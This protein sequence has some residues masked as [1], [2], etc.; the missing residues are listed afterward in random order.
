MKKNSLLCL[1]CVCL[2]LFLSCNAIQSNLVGDK[3]RKVILGFQLGMSTN[4]VNTLFNSYVASQKLKRVKNQYPFLVNSLPFGHE[5]YSSLISHYAPGDSILMG[6]SVYYSD[7]NDEN[8]DNY[9]DAN[10]SG[11]KYFVYAR[12]ESGFT[13]KEMVKDI[14]NNVSLEYGK[15]DETDTLKLNSDTKIE[16]KWKDRNDV[17]ITLYYTFFSEYDSILGYTANNYIIQLDYYYTSKMKE[18]MQLKKSIY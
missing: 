7:S 10:A 5:Y 18:S 15:F 1:V 6:I 13:D 9:T 17:D 2:L 4:E 14:I 16:Y 12:P 8:F 3:K 11:T